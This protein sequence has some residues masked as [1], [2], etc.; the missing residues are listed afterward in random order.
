M[1]IIGLTGGI[2]SG[3]SF[4]AS[5][6]AK[7]GIPIYES[8]LRAKELMATHPAIKAAL[9]LK[10]G[11]EAF[12]GEG[13]NKSFIAQQIFNNAALI[14]WINELVHPIVGQDFEQWVKSK[15]DEPLVIKEA[16]ILIESG[17]Y[18][19]CDQIIV[20]T[21]PENIRIERVMQRDNMTKNQ[22]M[23]RIQNQLPENEKIKFANYIIVNDGTM[24]VSE[25]VQ[26]IYTEIIN[27]Q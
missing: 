22:V 19:K 13:L 25:Q 2:G 9:I 12:M 21:A 20:V 18:K 15:K 10:L 24:V 3:K 27:S 4:I 6:F 11:D 1:K 16:A 8:D 26:K 23:E 7:F 14:K 5:E 17:A